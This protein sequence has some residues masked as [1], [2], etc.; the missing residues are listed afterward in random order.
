MVYNT[1]KSDEF[2]NIGFLNATANSGM[3]ELSI[4]PTVHLQLPAKAFA[5]NYKVVIDVAVM[6]VYKLHTTI[7]DTQQYVGVHEIAY[8][9]NLSRITLKGYRMDNY[10]HALGV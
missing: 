6:R 8:V 10:F 7:C 2:K 3:G 1:R 4:V 9:D 5:G